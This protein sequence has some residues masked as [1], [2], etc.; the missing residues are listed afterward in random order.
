M[1]YYMLVEE[2]GIGFFSIRRDINDAWPE[3]CKRVGDEQLQKYGYINCDI[4]SGK[5][6]VNDSRNAMIAT[7]LPSAIPLWNWDGLYK[8]ADGCGCNEP[9]LRAK[10]TARSELVKVIGKTKGINIENSAL[11][12]NAEEY[13]DQFLDESSAVYLFGENGSL[14]AILEPNRTV[15]LVNVYYSDKRNV[16]RCVN[17][18]NYRSDDENVQRYVLHEIETLS[19]VMNV[20]EGVI[21]YSVVQ[22]FYSTWKLLRNNFKTMTEALDFLYTESGLISRC[23]LE[24]LCTLFKDGLIEDGEEEAYT[25]FREVCEVSSTERE[26]LGLN[27]EAYENLDEDDFDDSAAW[28]DDS[29]FKCADVPESECTGHCMSCPGRPI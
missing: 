22:D 18:N 11:C 19:L 9:A 14:V 6:I 25:Y 26:W 17:E 16:Y 12:E 27:T 28:E 8:K 5:P 21:S 24:E 20:R 7:R 1:E 15:F 13:I 3:D 10:D 29:H 2:V 23:R 4:M